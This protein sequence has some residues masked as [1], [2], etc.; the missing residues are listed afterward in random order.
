[1]CSKEHE[2][3]QDAYRRLKETIKNTYPYG[4]FVALVGGQIVADANDFNELHALLKKAGKDPFQAFIIQAGHDY[5]EKAI[6]F[7][8]E[9]VL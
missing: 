4:R 7:L 1:M 5:L 6:I 8:N 2:L 9:I 3:N